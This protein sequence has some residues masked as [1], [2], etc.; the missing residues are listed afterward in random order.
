MKIY[1]V[2]HADYEKSAGLLK[3]RLPVP[4][5]NNGLSQA[6]NLVSFFEDKEIDIIFSSAVLRCKQTAEILSQSKM[7]IEFDKR[8]LEALIPYQGYMEGNWEFDAY[9]HQ[10]ELGGETI[11]D[12]QNR[13]IDFYNDLIK[14][15]FGKVIVCSHGDPLQFL[16]IHLLNK[17]IPKD[18][19]ILRNQFPN[20]QTKASVRLVEITEDEIQIKDL[21]SQEKLE[22]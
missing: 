17:E 1:L 4:L 21:Y 13:M 6:Q 11:K 15:P 5:S 8:L 18:Y 7:K 22:D 2:R 20:Y 12:V 10:K 16:Y 3:G 9:T 14:K 19:K